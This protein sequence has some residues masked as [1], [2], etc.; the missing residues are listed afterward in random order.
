MV[1]KKLS[2]IEEGLS[3]LTSLSNLLIIDEMDRVAYH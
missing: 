2:V 1:H 3:F